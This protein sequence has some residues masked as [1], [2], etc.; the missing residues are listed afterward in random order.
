NIVDTFFSAIRT[1]KDEVVASLIE[2]ALVTPETTDKN[3]RTPLL[4]A[5]EA[6][7]IRTV[8]QLMDFDANVN[9]FGITAS[10]PR[11]IDYHSRRK[12]HTGP[13]IYHIYR[14]PLQLAASLGN[15]TIVKLLIETYSADDGIIAPDGQHALRL[16]VKAGHRE[17]VNYLPV[18]RGGGWRRWKVKHEKAMRRAKN[19]GRGI[20]RFGK[21]FVWD[22]PKFLLWTV[23]KEIIVAPIME[24]LRWLRDHGAEIPGMIWD[25]VK[26]VGRGILIVLE[27]FGRGLKSIG[28]G[29]LKA[30]R[31]LWSF[32]TGLVRGLWHLLKKIPGLLTS[33]LKFV[34]HVIKATPAAIARFLARVFKVVLDIVD[35]IWSL[36]VELTKI[37]WRAIKATPSALASVF[38][39]LWKGIKSIAV[40]IGS[41]F[42]SIFS[43][44]H[45]LLSGL[46]TF[47]RDITFQDVWNGFVAVL[48]SVF[49]AAPLKILEWLKSFGQFS[50]DLMEKMF[51]WLGWL[52]WWLVRGLIEF[53]VYVPKKLL[54][55]L[56]SV[57]SSIGGAVQEVA[58]WVNPKR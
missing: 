16:A 34:W 11:T 46:V 37:L 17:I 33:A 57:G 41:V 19:A 3:G 15:L 49:V 50:Y 9:A 24:G 4:A 2:N 54:E 32:L 25:G 20:Y 42:T 55:I 14:T 1:K 8:Q 45:T 13:E 58:I 51:G 38:L 43:F 30:P 29:I 56:A 21:F 40:A 5:I 7:N 39:W 26:A 23:P 36:T 6:G 53:V 22:V 10:I 18:R 48:H 47:F 27:G 12:A 35:I 44:L 28:R 52:V 31:I